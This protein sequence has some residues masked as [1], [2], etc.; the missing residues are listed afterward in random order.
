MLSVD[1]IGGGVAVG[2]VIHDAAVV[3][4]SHIHPTAV[5]FCQANG[6]NQAVG[7][8]TGCVG[9]KVGLPIDPAGVRPGF[10]GECRG[11]EKQEERRNEQDAGDHDASLDS[12]WWPT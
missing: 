8:M 5:V 3:A 12:C 4:I 2:G 10:L 7:V 1:S 9:G 6:E 11:S